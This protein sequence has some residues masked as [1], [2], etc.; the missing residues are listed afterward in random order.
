[1]VT[2]YGFAPKPWVVPVWQ[3]ALSRHQGLG[4]RV[5]GKGC[6]TPVAVAPDAWLSSP[7]SKLCQ[8]LGPRGEEL[9]GD[10]LRT[11]HPAKMMRR[12][13]KI[14][15]IW[16]SHMPTRKCAARKCVNK[17]KCLHPHLHP[18]L[19]LHLHLYLYLNLCLYEN[20]WAT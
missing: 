17:H 9:L 1:M 11:Q 16:S 18:Y 10:S 4:F 20:R 2:A 5:V 19:H 7:S 13:H 8:V 15:G 3:S 12:V 6:Q 14:Y